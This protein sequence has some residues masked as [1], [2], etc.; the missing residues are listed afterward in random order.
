M[1]KVLFL[2]LSLFMVIELFGQSQGISY[3][4]VIVDKKPLEIP[5]ADITGNILPNHKLLVRF[6][7]LDS[8]GTTEYQEEHATATDEFGMISL[9]IGQGIP[10]AT[11]PKLFKE[12]DWDGSPKDLKVDISL[13]DVDVF[14]MDFSYQELTFVPY[15]YHKNITA[16]GTLMVDGVTSLKSRLNVTNGSPTF[17]SGA[18]TVDKATTLKNSLSVDS[19]SSL[20]GQV[21]ITADVNGD[22]TDYKSYPLRVEGSNQ[23]IAVKI[24]GGRSSDNYFVTFWDNEKIQGRIEGQ[25]TG[26]L[27]TDPE[28]IFDNILFANEIIRSTVDV[29]KAGAGVVAASTSSTVCV[30]LGAC[31][32]SPVPSLIA[33]AIAETVM[34]AANLALVVAEP[35]I[36]NVSKH[37]NIGVSYQSGAGDY[38]EWL[39]KAN[40]NESIMPGDVVGVKGGFISKAT[41]NAEFY[42]VISHQPIVLGNMPEN[43]K[44]S[45]YEKVAF[46]GQVP[47]KVFGKVNSGD[48][49][50]PSGNNNGA[51]IAISRENI[52]PEQFRQIIGV[53]WASSASTDYGYV[54]VAVGLNANDVAQLS[55]KQDA[56]IKAQEAEINSLKDQLNKMNSVLAQLIPNYTQMMQTANPLASSVQTTSRTADYGGEQTVIYKD[57]TREQVVEGI[58][59]AE[60]MMKAKGVDINTHPFFIKMKSDPSYKESLI[61]DILTSVSKEINA[62]YELDVKAGVKAVKL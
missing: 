35:I 6:T 28:Y 43:G 37:A 50:I 58:A 48:Y 32:T 21:T 3:Q 24:D 52:Q 27:L 29:V 13:S 12:I 18:L 55:V 8:L 33:G 31:V 30:G 38:A 42:M 62:K 20:K 16:T 9:M 54:N 22:N 23:G 45:D 47:V 15:A 34:E 19:S 10:G 17:L 25:T 39:P 57:I 4:A 46:M 49:I 53:A 44:E 61:N 41:E 1:K 60:K 2:A 40:V 59:L 56:K 51:G 11:S 5:G 26:E 7:I 14:F 36:Y